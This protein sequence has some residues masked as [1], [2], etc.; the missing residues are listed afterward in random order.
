MPGMDG[1]GP[2]GDG[3][4]GR[5]RGPCG[6]GLAYGRGAGRGMGLGLGW[7]RGAGIGVVPE[8]GQTAEMESLRQKV[9]A[10]TAAIEEL[11][12]SKNEPA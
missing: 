9:E 11:R 5:G 1:T 12:A 4:P 7:R 3:R 2:F 6:R 8:D 10:L